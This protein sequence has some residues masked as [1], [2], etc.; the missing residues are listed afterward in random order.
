[1]AKI[2]TSNSELKKIFEN[3]CSNYK[4][5]SFVTAWAGKHYISDIL[6][7][8]SQKIRNSV[9]GLHFYQTSPRFIED[10][11]E[12]TTLQYNKR[13]NT[14]VFH[15]KV[16]L[17]YNNDYEWNAIVGSSNLTGGGF[18]RNIECNVQ[19]TSEK[20]ASE[21]YSSLKE[22]INSSWKSSEPMGEFFEQ[23][24]NRYEEARK[25]ISFFK[26]PLNSSV[27]DIDWSDYIHKMI[28]NESID[29]TIKSPK[30]ETRLKLLQKAEELFSKMSLYDFP[31]KYPWAIAGLLSE[32]DGV[33]DWQFFGSL[34]ANGNFHKLFNS[35][36]GRKQISDALDLIPFEGDVTKKNFDS[37]IA[38][39][40]KATNL[41]DIKAIATRFLAIKRP[42]VFVGINNK[43][44]E[45][46]NLLATNRKTLKL[47]QYWDLI[48]QNIKISQ[49][50]NEN[51]NDIPDDQKL[52]YKYRAAM[53]DALYYKN[54]D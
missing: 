6:L 4:Y 53:L 20:D 43:N 27:K 48:V 2:I 45:I 33:E 22:L 31:D 50:Y 14:D 46:L 41:Y 3:N 17:F 12:L 15:P 10:F 47:D 36:K 16:Y 29:G 26:R 51:I 40:R 11:M 13:M 37:Y 24:S 8:N 38:K 25:K 5:I 34:G 19:M 28:L 18:E 30:I 23:Y 39:M 7:K 1:M 44:P 9:V 21:I 35:S 42:D 54:E 32:Y 52:I 49:W